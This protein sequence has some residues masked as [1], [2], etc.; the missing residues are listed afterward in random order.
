M[1]IARGWGQDANKHR[2]EDYIIKVTDDMINRLRI[3]KKKE[4][5]QKDI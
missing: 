2:C 4:K 1:S 3:G 5:N